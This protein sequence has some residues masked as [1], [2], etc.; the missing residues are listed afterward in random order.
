MNAATANYRWRQAKNWVMLGLCGLS[1]I[2]VMVPLFLIISYLVI[3]GVGSIN[4]QLFTHL[5]K[6]VGEAGGGMGNAILG[7]LLLLSIAVG[8]GVPIGIMSGLYL[9]EYGESKFAGIARFLIE[10]LNATPS[11]VVGIFAY[12]M[13]VV[14]MGGF[15]A[16]AGG[17]ALAVMM[18]PTVARATEEVVGTVPQSLREAALALGVSSWRT[19]W[20]IVLRTA[21]PGIVTGVML[22]LSR[23]AGETAPLL[24][25][26]FNNRNWSISAVQPISSLP[27]QI[28]SYAISPYEEWHRQA[29]AA[30]LV[31][32]SIIF[33]ISLL[34]RL[35]VRQPKGYRSH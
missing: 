24:F 31:L 12:T 35:I 28:F 29:W 16:L 21:A 7:T 33:I 27:V 3:K 8:I 4:I 19:T 22:A 5:P 10:T 15:S 9:A 17:A 20:S 6:P 18:I 34:A 25:T 32:I 11:I 23:V 30:G 2:I 1:A 13:V 14:P 26:A